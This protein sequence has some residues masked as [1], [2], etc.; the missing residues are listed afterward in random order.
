VIR[1]A[2]YYSKVLSN[3]YLMSREVVI[4]VLTVSSAEDFSSKPSR[5]ESQHMNEV[6]KRKSDNSNVAE[7][8]VVKFDKMNASGI[9]SGQLGLPCSIHSLPHSV[10][11]RHSAAGNN[12]CAR[13]VEFTGLLLQQQAQVLATGSAETSGFDE[14]ADFTS[15]FDGSWWVIV[16]H[17]KLRTISEPTHSLSTF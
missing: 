17:V 10:G 15:V 2:A 8:H 14:E 12:E 13:D 6:S 3:A 4:D 9:G 1:S 16:I 5:R 7:V 11:V